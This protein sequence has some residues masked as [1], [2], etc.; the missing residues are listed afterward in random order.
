MTDEEALKDQIIDHFID[1]FNNSEGVAGWHLNED[2]AYWEE[3]EIYN[4]LLDLNKVR[5]PEDYI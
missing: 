5:F 2:I 4:L 1:I 3:F